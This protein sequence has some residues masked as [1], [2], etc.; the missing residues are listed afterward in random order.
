M[1]LPR[2]VTYDKE[3]G[4]FVARKMIFKRFSSKE[5]AIA[6]LEEK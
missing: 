1:D 2:G 6:F 5:E 4:K 3:R